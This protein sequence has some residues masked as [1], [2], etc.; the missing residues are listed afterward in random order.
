MLE[1]NTRIVLARFSDNNWEKAKDVV[2]IC[3]VK[4][5]VG[6]GGSLSTHWMTR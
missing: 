5:H 2:K 1:A 4:K 6:D 3:R